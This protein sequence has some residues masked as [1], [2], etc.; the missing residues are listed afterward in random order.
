MKKHTR[1]FLKELSIVA[2]GMV[3][4]TSMAAPLMSNGG[5]TASVGGMDIPLVSPA[6][7]QVA[8]I[9]PE[10]VTAEDGASDESLIEQL[11]KELEDLEKLLDTFSFG[12]EDVAIGTFQFPTATEESENRLFQR[13]CQWYGRVCR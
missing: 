9:E 13:G 5:A 1:S 11:W 10:A 8:L 4:G 7:E 6:V 2:A 3:L 12:V